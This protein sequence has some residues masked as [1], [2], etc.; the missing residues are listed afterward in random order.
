MGKLSAAERTIAQRLIS[1]AR[2]EIR[3]NAAA[4]GGV[5]E[6]VPQADWCTCGAPIP[7]GAKECGKH[8][9]L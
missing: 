8:G 9:L 4:N 2:K 5:Y 6:P 3:Q 1:A 7:R